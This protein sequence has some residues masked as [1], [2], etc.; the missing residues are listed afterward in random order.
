LV[1]TRQQ[2]LANIVEGEAGR[3]FLASEQ[4]QALTGHSHLFALRFTLGDRLFRY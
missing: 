3:G 2:S 4:D 1:T